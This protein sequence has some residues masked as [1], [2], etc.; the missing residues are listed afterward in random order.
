MGVLAWFFSLYPIREWLIRKAMKRPYTN[1]GSADGKDIYMYRYWLF[2]PYPA[3]GE[4]EKRGIW[5]YLPSV[6]L[7]RIMREDRDRDLH[8]HPWNARTFILEGF[9][10]EEREGDGYACRDRLAGTTDTLKYRE[11]HRIGYVSPGGVWTMFITGR[12]RGS[13]GFKVNGEHV[14]YRT[15]LGIE[16]D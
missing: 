2:N 15:Y 3:P 10:I 13:W 4:Y 14:P 6:R 7:H 11:Y 8:D 16:N 1:I 12:K 9:Y 5:N